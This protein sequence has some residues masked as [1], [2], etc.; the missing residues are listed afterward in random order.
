MHLL[1]R[2]L[3]VIVLPQVISQSTFLDFDVATNSYKETDVYE[4]LLLLHDQIRRF[5]DSN[6][7]EILTVVFRHAPLNRSAGTESINIKTVELA[8]LLHLLDRWSNVID[9]SSSIIRHL[10]GSIFEMP[11]LRPDSPVQ[12]MQA[13]LDREKPTTDE[14]NEYIK[15]GKV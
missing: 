12:G 3:N 11:K 14:I 13:E 7:T 5:N 6:T 4:A 2:K 10:D 15:K 8:S 9:L 1:A